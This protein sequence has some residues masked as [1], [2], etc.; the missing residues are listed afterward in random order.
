MSKY[1][2]IKKPLCPP[3]KLK[4]FRLLG[5]KVPPPTGFTAVFEGAGALFPFG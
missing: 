2:L 1:K 3:E 5:R 4:D